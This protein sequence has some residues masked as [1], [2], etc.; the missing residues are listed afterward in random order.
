MCSCA[1]VEAEK[2]ADL[3]VGTI[4]RKIVNDTEVVQMYR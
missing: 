4:R 2:E 3:T 1:H